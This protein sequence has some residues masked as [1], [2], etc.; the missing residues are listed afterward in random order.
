LET[1]ITEYVSCIV[2][3]Q[4]S[5]AVP[6]KGLASFLKSLP[7]SA[8]ERVDLESIDVSNH[9][10]CRC[11]SYSTR[12]E[13]CPASEFP[14]VPDIPDRAVGFDVS[15]QELARALETVLYAVSRKP[16][17]PTFT[18]VYFEVVEGRC[19]LTGLDGYRIATTS[20]DADC[21]EPVQ[22]IVP[23]KACGELLRLLEKRHEDVTVFFFLTTEEERK[24]SAAFSRA[25]FTLSGVEL[26]AGLIDGTFPDYHAVI[27][28]VTPLGSA[29]VSRG[30]LLEAV[31]YLAAFKTAQGERASYGYAPDR[32]DLTPGE[33]VLHLSAQSGTAQASVDVAACVIGNMV[34]Q[35]RAAF[36]IDLL[37]HVLGDEVTLAVANTG[38][39]SVFVR[40]GVSVHALACLEKPKVKGESDE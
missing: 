32:V 11:G 3:E 33:G 14:I 15:A 23:L 6:V 18:G 20:I 8:P 16:E 24:T 36:L 22:G 28:P 25:W 30:E 29:T 40:E 37:E 34:H 1:S 35:F 2:Q 5:I 21:V 31:K 13:C 39:D 19:C 26:C 7:T 4:G 9:L 10:D 27:R 12:L 17:R 38:V